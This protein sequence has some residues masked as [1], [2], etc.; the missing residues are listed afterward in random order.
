MV[1]NKTF[2]R[3]RKAVGWEEVV[4]LK[5]GEITNSVKMQVFDVDINWEKL[6][7]KNLLFAIDLIGDKSM[8]VLVFFLDNRD[9]ENKVLANKEM[10][11]RGTGISRKT[12][13]RVIKKLIEGNI[14]KELEYN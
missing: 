9:Y 13:Y 14:I 2:G 1:D 6:W 10:I 11:V 5:T 3:G 8:Q 4:S 12:V 7:L